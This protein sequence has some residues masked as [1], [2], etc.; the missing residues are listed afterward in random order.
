M[1]SSRKIAYRW[2]CRPRSLDELD[3]YEDIRIGS[4]D[5]MPRGVSPYERW[6]ARGR[7]R[8]EV[9][10]S[11]KPLCANI[12]RECRSSGVSLDKLDV[13]RNAR[14]NDSVFGALMAQYEKSSTYTI[15][16]A[17][18]SKDS[19]IRAVTVCVMSRT[20]APCC[21]RQHCRK[22]RARKS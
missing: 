21:R 5:D 10:V 6:R 8:V 9:V 18:V 14:A 13:N 20:C 4:M 1:P 15:I 2:M 22:L 7:V 16:Y 12:Y 3:A 11:M 17:I 19:L